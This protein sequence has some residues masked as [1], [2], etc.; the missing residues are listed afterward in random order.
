MILKKKRCAKLYIIYIV[1]YIVVDHIVYC[2]TYFFFIMIK[3][4]V[5]CAQSKAITFL[6][7]GQIFGFIMGSRETIFIGQD[8]DH[9]IRKFSGPIV[10]L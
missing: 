4:V 5:W 6:F 3:N 7:C 2:C 9:V 8:L 10:L 1:V